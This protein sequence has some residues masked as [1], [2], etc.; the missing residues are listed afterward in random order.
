MCA[1]EICEGCIKGKQQQKNV[2]KKVEFKA[3]RSG[4]KI[5]YNIVSIEHKS[6][7]GTKFWL[8]FVD[9]RNGFKWSYF[10]KT[11]KIHRMWTPVYR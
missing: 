6:I 3:V 10:L 7:E 9:E 11:K 8:M 5:Y 2:S 1:D 4:E